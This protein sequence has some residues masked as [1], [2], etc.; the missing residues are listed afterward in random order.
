MLA[1]RVVVSKHRE[2]QAD[3]PESLPDGGIKPSYKTFFENVA[4]LEY[5]VATGTDHITFTNR[6][7]ADYIEL[8][9][10]SEPFVFPFHTKTVTY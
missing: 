1:Q 10:G 5:L 6:S 8:P 7:K 9:F 2:N 3:V 4:K